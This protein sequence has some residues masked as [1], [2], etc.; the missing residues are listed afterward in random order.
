MCNGNKI[1][2]LAWFDKGVL[3][4][5]SNGMQDVLNISKE[6]KPMSLN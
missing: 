4:N 1:R 6:E 2:D 3:L 5:V